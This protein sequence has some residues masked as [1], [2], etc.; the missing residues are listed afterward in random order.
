MCKENDS[1]KIIT[2]E[3]IKNY[4]KLVYKIVNRMNYGYVDKEDLIQAGFLGLVKALQK[5]DDNKSE[6]F[7]SYASIY[8]ISSIKICKKFGKTVEK[9]K[10]LDF[11]IKNDYT[12]LVKL[13]KWNSS[14]LFLLRE[15]T[16]GV[17]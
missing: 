8:I 2:D 15:L 7:I 3:Q 1:Y 14:R 17:S 4:E 5:Y 10:R 6:S 12:M 16:F 13:K 11:L 9:Y